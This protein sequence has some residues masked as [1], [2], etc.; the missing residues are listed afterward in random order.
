MAKTMFGDEAVT[1]P[2]QTQTMFGDTAAP[3]PTQPEEEVGTFEDISKGAASGLLA[4]PQGITELGALGIDYAFDTNTSRD[5]TGAFESVRDTLGIRPQGTAGQVTESI[6]NFAG[7]AIPVIGFLSRAS[8]VA[9]GGKVLESTSK[10]GRA[11]EA[12]GSSATGKALLSSRPR[13]A[14]TTS[15][16]AGVADL[17]VSKDGQATISDGF[18]ALPEALNTE[19]DTGLMGR[20][21]AARRF[22]NKLRVGAEGAGISGAFEV[23]FPVIGGVA[24]G[25]SQIP[26]VSSAANV[27]S[28]GFSA[29]GDKFAQN[30]T[31]KKW[32]TSAGLTPRELYEDLT[33]TEALVDEL[34]DAASK[35]LAAFDT[36]AKKVVKGQGILGVF[37]LGKGGITKAHDDLLRFLEGDTQALDVYGKE[38]VSA[39]QTMRDQ[40]D[41]L[42]DI[43]SRQLENVS[44]EVLDP[45]LKAKLLAELEENKGSYLRRIYN[46]ALDPEKV[47]DGSIKETPMYKSAVGEVAKILR[48]R[49]KSYVKSGIMKELRELD[50]YTAD[51]ARM[52][53]GE[54][55]GD[56]NDAGVDAVQ[57]IRNRK[58]SMESGAKAL[59]AD[60]RKPLYEISE[61]LL[62]DRKA[63]LDKA[64]SFRALINQSRDPKELYLRTVGDL[65]NIVASNNLYDNFAATY[66]QGIAGARETINAGGRPLVVSSSNLSTS[67]ADFLVGQGYKQLGTF[68]KKSAFGGKYGSLS[69]DYVAPEVYSALTIPMRAQTGL[70]EALAISLQAKG[71][72]Q[73]AKTVLNPLAQV[74]NFLS[75]SFF[76]GA[77]GNVMRNMELGD[78]WR[79]TWGKAADLADDDFRKFYEMTGKLGVRDQNL[80]VN[81]FRQLLREGKDLEYSGRMAAGLQTIL[82]KTPGVRGLQK[83]YSGTD[84]FWKISGMLAEKAKYAAAFRKAGINLDDSQAP[85]FAAAVESLIRSGVAPRSSG[86]AG[87]VD[88]VHFFDLLSSDIVKATM[89]T[90][91]RVPEAIKQIR[92]IP[93]VGNF[94]AFP[95]EIVRNTANIFNQG[96]KEMSFKATP[97]LVEAVGEKAARQMQK[98]IRAIGA[99]R[100]TSYV[101]M[102]YVVPRSAQGAAMELTGTTAEDMEALNRMV[103]EYLRGHILIP[104]NKPEKGKLQYIDFSYMNPYDFALSPARQALRIYNEKG[105]VSSNEVANLTAGLWQGVKTFF[106]P[107][108]GESLIAERIQDVLPQN[109]FGRGG[110]TGF[111]AEIYGKSEDTG[112]QLRRSM[113][114]ILGG[115]NPGLIEQFALER[116][117]EFV[118]GRATRAAFGI[119]GRQGQ[120][121]STK[122]ELLTAVTGLRR[123]DLDLPNTLFY[124]GYEYSDLRT[125]A[126][127]N[128][129]TVAKRN[130]ATEQEIID[131]YR[132]T[133]QDL[134]RAQ[135]KLMQV[136]EAARQLGMSDGDIRY[137][138]KK[139]A[140]VGNRELNAVMRGVFEPIKISTNLRQDIAREA[141]MRKQP[142][143]VTR[144]PEAELAKI[145]NEMFGIK[146]RPE[147]PVEAQT[148]MFGDTPAP[149]TAPRTTMFGDTSAPAPVPA[150][151]PQTAPRTTMFGDTVA[152]APSP[153]SQP[154]NEV[155]PILVPDP[156]TRATFGA[157]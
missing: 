81:E 154:R 6:V 124:R 23:A 36:A 134:Y 69:G 138:L 90:Y 126:V 49:D 82:D 39:G 18:D 88:D 50:D 120:E 14:V 80:Q 155:S 75:G 58:E 118:P 114:H 129:S 13:Q 105:E 70:G 125:D 94:V 19:E 9:Q 106:E 128:F 55:L 40:I 157:K 62:K 34:T 87:V 130:D 131:T 110:K 67:D 79:L 29:L 133:N 148:T 76:L 20:D 26:G 71:L 85:K 7:A 45:K 147:E 59:G 151:R 2:S 96:L 102:A 33:S 74:R 137:A 127:G 121:S 32:F 24:R 73:M 101:G 103:P 145:R 123:M 132:R 4:I 68:D 47:I 139:E 22:R 17:F 111:G 42:T 91:S 35:N 43:L 51:A 44:E 142:R 3:A 92:R 64:P 89:P 112:T 107:F 48:N 117:G 99:Q 38:V 150:P 86:L 144:L 27:I 119:P 46:G 135:A 53:D 65:S 152:P 93:L 140:N 16:A 122:E 84:T 104:L 60:G 95:A 100:M 149:A 41:G 78:S 98:E 136:V 52:I 10:L 30:K 83:I 61:G 28:R 25:A 113:N 108:A 97:E 143:L 56:I 156:V 115:F 21:E 57:A 116:G 54:L 77:N 15:V 63:F 31:M 153:A 72:S 141:F 109:Y 8:R 1:T 37:G 5:V 12:L 146:L 11:A 66:R